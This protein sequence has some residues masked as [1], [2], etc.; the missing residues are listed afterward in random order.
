MW[1]SCAGAGV[2]P[3]ADPGARAVLQRAG[4][5]A[6]P[7]HARGPQRQPGVQLQ[8]LPGLR[9]LGHARPPALARALLQ[10]GTYPPVTPETIKCARPRTKICK[11]GLS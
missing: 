3:V 2:D 10:G 11:L 5:R 7:R 8:H 4:L 6:Q 9:A 1:W